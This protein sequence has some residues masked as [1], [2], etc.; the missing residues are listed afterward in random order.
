MIVRIS[1]EGQFELAD[2]ESGR[3]NELE[4]AVIAAVEA[5]DEAAYA[6]AF[7]A[8]LDYVRSTGSAVA[9]DTLEGSDVILPPS[10][11]SL[12]RGGVG[13]HGR[14]IDPGLASGARPALTIE[15]AAVGLRSGSPRGGTSARSRARSGVPRRPGP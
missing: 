9:E 3:L 15:E 7:P 11:I 10:D 12:E 13:I 2:S 5:C 14:G 4:A 1:G 8:L 6:A